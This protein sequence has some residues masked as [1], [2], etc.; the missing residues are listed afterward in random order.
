MEK[1]IGSDLS[2]VAEQAKIECLA[3]L[4]DADVK[5]AAWASI[6]D[7]ASTESIYNREAKMRGFYSWS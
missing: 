3:G 4:P 1:V 5:A 6:T 7:P 2:D